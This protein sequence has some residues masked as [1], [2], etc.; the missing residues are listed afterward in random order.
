MNSAAPV[1]AGH[2]GDRQAPQVAIVCA[3]S[4]HRRR[5]L[6]RGCEIAGLAVS[7]QVSR[8]RRA[9]LRAINEFPALVLF[10]VQPTDEA[11]VATAH[12]QLLRPETRAIV[13]TEDQDIRE[14]DAVARSGAAAYASLP[15]DVA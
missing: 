13:L 2:V 3:G 9:V 12:L 7:S 11:I 10:A 15:I 14:L 6:R 4:K 5:L 8:P 1:G